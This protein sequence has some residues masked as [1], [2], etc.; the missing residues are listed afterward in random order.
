MDA[1]HVVTLVRGEGAGV[2]DAHGQRYVDAVASLW[3]CQVGH[4]RREIAE[5]ISRQATT[6]AGF[7]TFDRFSNEPADTLAAR[8]VSLAPMADARVF[9]TSGGSESVDTAMKLAR[10]AH[11]LSDEP[12]R[13]LIV[14]RQ[15]SYHGVAYGAST[16][17]GLPANQAGFGPLVPNVEQ[18][19]YDD[20]EALDK[21]IADRGDELAAIIAEPVV[22]AGGVLPPPDG[23]LQ[24]L[25]ARCDETGAYLILDEVICGF[26]RLGQW[27]G[28]QHYGVVPDMVTFA[29]GVTSGYQPSGGVLLGPR[30]RGPLEADAS[31]VLRHGFTYS[32]HPTA[33]AAALANLAIIEAEGLAGRAEG[34]G[35]RLGA[36]LSALV[37]G[38]TV[39]EVRGAGAMRG[40]VLG[41]GV[42]ATAVRDDL[43]GRGVITRALGGDVLAFCPPLVIGDEDLDHCAEA[44]GEAIA[45]VASRR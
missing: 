11:V 30:V 3:Y 35:D 18:V 40:V 36:G 14:S 9:L 8:L 4:G 17:T 31:Y 26:G 34:I 5:A 33:C 2:W 16:V 32:G 20:L 13:S 37:D 23:Y 43:L 42:D 19:P 12:R 7:H 24:G 28:A 22:G 21:L 10:L 44:T 38:D 41:E 27:W 45:S 1:G 6:M 29:K 15:P 25:R 39:I